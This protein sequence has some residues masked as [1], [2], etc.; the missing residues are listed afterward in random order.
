MSLNHE[1]HQRKKYSKRSASALT[2]LMPG[3]GFANNVQNAFT[4]DHF[5]MFATLTNRRGNFHLTLL[6]GDNR[7]HLAN[8]A[9]P[10][11]ST[12]VGNP[13]AF[14]IIRGKLHRNLVAG[15]DSDKIL[16]HLAAD[17]R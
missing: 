13:A 5:A 1:K 6:N 14:Q 3:I 7:L 12:S 11:E 16:T 15:K 4:T 10:A 9:W 2:H 8:S 17:M